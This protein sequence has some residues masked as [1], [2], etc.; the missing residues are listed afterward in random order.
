[1]TLPGIQ[2]FGDASERRGVW[3]SLMILLPS[4]EKRDA[5]L[6]E[7]WREG[8]GATR[9]FASALPDY[10]YLKPFV[11]PANCRNARDFAERSLSISNS[12]WLDEAKFGRIV[13]VVKRYL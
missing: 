12:H 10:D 13:A 7:L 6:A 3:P 9:M 8:L 5:I 11:A 2:V 4:E 1:M